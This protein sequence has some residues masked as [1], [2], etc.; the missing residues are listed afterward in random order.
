MKFAASAFDDETLNWWADLEDCRRYYCDR[1]IS[2]WLDMKMVVRE[3]FCQNGYKEVLLQDHDNS[4][5]ETRVNRINK[6]TAELR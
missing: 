6:G 2:T 5:R 4:G 3:R 1:S